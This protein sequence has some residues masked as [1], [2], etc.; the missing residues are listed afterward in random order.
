[1]KSSIAVLI[2]S[3][4]ANYLPNIV[5]YSENTIKSYRDTFVLLFKYS[6]ICHLCPHGRISIEI[7]YEENILNFLAWLEGDRNTGISTRNQRLAALKSFGKYVSS[8]APEYLDT[9]QSVLNIKTKKGVCKTVDY[10]T[11]TAVSLLLAQPNSKSK[12]GIRDLALLSL[13]Y[14]SGCRV[15]EIIDIK[16]GNISFINPA[17][18]TVNGKGNKIRVIPISPQVATILKKYCAGHNVSNPQQILFTNNRKEPLTRS[19]V[20]YI[21]KKYADSAKKQQPDLFGKNIHPHVL[22][23]S[24]AMHLLE[25]GVNL[26]YIRDFLG[27]SSVT[28][29]EIYA[30]S[31]PEI[32]RQF[33][34]AAA[35][36]LDESVEK[37]STKEKQSLLE[38]LKNSI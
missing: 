23:H 13:L 32:K 37:F 6:D 25:S 16:L 35:I 26:I 15:Q 5:G 22:R 1:M 38:W 9:F 21:L 11:T 10:L 12:K 36:K 34:E 20:S 29:T 28:T 14:E 17:T 24:K 4:F 8:T 19:G 2:T 33:L 18:I 27:H 31:N 30:K 7:F 3:Y